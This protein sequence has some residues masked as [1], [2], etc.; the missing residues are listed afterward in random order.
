MRMHLLL[1]FTLKIQCFL[2]CGMNQ[3]LL[4]NN[5]I[6]LLSAFFLSR[7]INLSTSSQFYLMETETFK[8]YLINSNA[9]YTNPQKE[10]HHSFR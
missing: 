8:C 6:I 9:I 1:L 4:L 10:S 7:L 3:K 5:I 2:I